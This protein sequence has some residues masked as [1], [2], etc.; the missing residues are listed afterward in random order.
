MNWVSIQ[1]IYNLEINNGYHILCRLYATYDKKFIYE[2]NCDLLKILKNK[3]IKEAIN[4]FEQMLYDLSLHAYFR[5]ICVKLNYDLDFYLYNSYLAYL[6]KFEYFIKIDNPINI[7]KKINLNVYG[8]EKNTLIN[9]EKL[10][11]QCKIFNKQE[12]EIETHSDYMSA[13]EKD[14]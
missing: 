12:R 6:F 11:Q 8:I 2:E 10:N 13:I 7:L 3:K 1:L 5:Y 9:S 14:N 4:N